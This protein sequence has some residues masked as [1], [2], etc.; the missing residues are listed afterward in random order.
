MCQP[1][2]VQ[3][4]PNGMNA[5]A[6]SAVNAETIGARM[7][8]SS[9]AAAGENASLRIELHEVGDR[10]QQAERAGAVRAVAELHPAHHL[11]LDQR[12]V[13]EEAE[14]DVDDDQ[15]L[16]ERD[17]PRLVRRHAVTA[18]LGL[19]DLDDAAEAVRVLERDARDARAQA[20]VDARRQRDRAAVRADGDE[21]AGRDPAPPRVVGRELELRL[22]PLEL[23][24]RDALDGGAG[25]ERLVRDEADL[26]LRW[27]FCC[28]SGSAG[29]STC[30]GASG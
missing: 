13:R 24:L 5:N 25:E 21:V 12:Q 27:A 19:R 2:T 30:S 1:L 16:D 22:R 20:A 26:A 8:G 18:L 28:G 3:P 10:L 4:G 29:A 9:I 15:R 7:Y 23:E 6:A 14:Q 17:P 11:P